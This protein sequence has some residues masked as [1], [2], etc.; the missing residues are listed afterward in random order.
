[1]SADPARTIVL[2]CPDWPVFAACRELGLDP[3]APIALTEGGLV[4]ACS[5]AARRDGVVRGLKLREAQYRSP[6]VTVLDYDAA[7]D[8]RMFEPVVRASTTSP[9]GSG[10]MNAADAPGSTIRKG[11]APVALAA[12]SAANGPSAT[13]TRAP[14]TPSGATVARSATAAA[15]SPP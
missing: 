13:P 9:T 6:G 8:A 12:C 15:S 2:W 5:A 11:D 10:A 1:M 3:A 4:F 7:L 14:S